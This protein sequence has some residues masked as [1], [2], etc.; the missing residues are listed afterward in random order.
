MRL[1]ASPPPDPSTITVHRL[2]VASEGRPF[3]RPVLVRAMELARPARAEIF[4]MTIARVYGT[5]LGFPNPWLQPMKREW[6]EQRQ[7]ARRAVDTFQ[8]AGFESS[9]LVFSTRRPRKRFLAEAR[10]RGTDAI[11]M[12]CDQDRGILG[13]FA[14]SHEPYRV[15]RHAGIPV[16]LVPVK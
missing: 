2:M 7:N 10:A 4:V 15:A 9:A 3:A 5:S 12:G 11:V 16:Y 13:D 8:K 14:W 6:E 1:R